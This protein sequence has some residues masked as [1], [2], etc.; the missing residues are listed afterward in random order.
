MC[1]HDSPQ[2]DDLRIP[3][4]K[5]GRPVS[6]TVN[7]ANVQA[8][9][10]ETVHAV[11]TAAGIR[12]LRVTRSGETRGVFCGMGICYECL[13]TVDNVPDQRACMTIVKDRM[14]ISTKGADSA[15]KNPALPGKGASH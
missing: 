2:K 3:T 7:G 8:Y 15:P 4:A 6:I 1:Q 9:E 11:L 5:Q 14:E 12:N 10:G 13:V